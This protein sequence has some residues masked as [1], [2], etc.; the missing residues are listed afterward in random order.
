MSEKGQTI[1]SIFSLIVFPNVHDGMSKSSATEFKTD[2]SYIVV[3]IQ[4][5]VLYFAMSRLHGAIVYFYR[6]FWNNRKKIQAIN[7]INYTKMSYGPYESYDMTLY[8]IMSY[9]PYDIFVFSKMQQNIL[10]VTSNN[11]YSLQY[12]SYMI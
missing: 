9:G 1:L 4:L 5:G 7:D 11:R 10:Y 3:G 2:L 8:H 12:M 6:N